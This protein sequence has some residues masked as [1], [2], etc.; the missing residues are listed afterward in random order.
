[1]LGGNMFKKLNKIFE[2]HLLKIAKELEIIN[3]SYTE[4]ERIKTYHAETGERFNDIINRYAI[5]DEQLL[6]I[7]ETVARFVTYTRITNIDKYLFVD[8]EMQIPRIIK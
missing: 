5:S 8:D 1:M 3:N 6:S 7:S 4:T 2:L